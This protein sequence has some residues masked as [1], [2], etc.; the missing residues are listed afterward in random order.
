MRPKRFCLGVVVL[1]MGVGAS[2]R[3]EPLTPQEEVRYLS[4]EGQPLQTFTNADLADYLRLCADKRGSRA[5]ATALGDDI[6]RWA[7]RTV[8]QPYRAR[9][10][11]F[12]YAETDCI[13][14]VERAL[15]LSLADNWT[16]YRWAADRL[17][18]RNGVADFLET[19]FFTLADWLPNNAWLFEDISN[20]IGPTEEFVDVAYRRRFLVGLQFGEDDTPLGR[21]KTAR[22]AAKL[23][24]VPE[25]EKTVVRYTPRD[26]I[27]SVQ[28]RLKNG[29]IALFIRRCAPP[30][31]RPWYDCDHMGLIIVDPAQ[32]AIAIHAVPPKVRQ[33]TLGDLLDTFR[34]VA[35][36]KF[37]R[38]REGARVVV[39]EGLANPQ[40]NRSFPEPSAEDAR[41]ESLREARGT[42]G[43]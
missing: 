23:A 22:K 18:Y 37:L 14:H 24:A 13:V 31:L 20:R 34:F 15:A 25:T 36:I 2:S 30:G 19:N 12:D 16:S 6:A 7:L 40:T 41:V 35:G 39:R 5:P 43:Q 11:R 32:G 28:G 21:A 27:P 17:R 9:A 8:N 42:P 33:Q 26:A 4:L 29:D 38:V 1:V 3:G 10:V